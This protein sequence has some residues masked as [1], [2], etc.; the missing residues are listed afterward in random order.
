MT[1][2]QILRKQ[3]R[4][5]TSARSVYCNG[6]EKKQNL[7]KAES[8]PGG[9]YEEEYHQRREAEEESNEALDE[10]IRHRILRNRRRSKVVSPFKNSVDPK[11][12]AVS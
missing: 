7:V 8:S 10:S 12:H 9:R 1:K 11:P 5:E 6:H 3:N 4:T 2:T